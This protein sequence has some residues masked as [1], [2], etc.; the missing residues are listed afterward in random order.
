MFS[1][2]PR[3]RDTN[4]QSHY[5][6]PHVPSPLSSSPLRNSPSPL[7]PRDANVPSRAADTIMSSPTK[8]SR[9]K[10]ESH[11]SSTTPSPNALPSPPPSRKESS[12]SKRTT[13]VNPLIHGRASADEGRETRRKLFLKNVREAS[14][15]K[16]WKNRGGDEEIMRCIWVAEQRRLEERMRKEVMGIEADV[17][18][19]ELSIDEV[20]ADEVALNEEQELEALLGYLDHGTG[21]QALD[22]PMLPQH[23]MNAPMWSNSNDQKPANSASQDHVRSD[24]PYGSDDEYDDIFMDVIHEEERMSS[25]QQSSGYPQDQDMMDMS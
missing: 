19:E 7:S 14:E 23:N 9:M 1:T 20:M 11:I 15:E 25:Q 22:E 6:T 13:K 18:E 16:R 3:L 24:T 4:N 10:T 5:Y 12:F 8:P 21:N 17:E 2:L